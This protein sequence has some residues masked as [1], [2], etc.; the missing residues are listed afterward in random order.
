VLLRLCFTT[1]G[2]FFTLV[3]AVGIAIAQSSNAAVSK[4]EPD[5][6]AH[7][8]QPFRDPRGLYSLSMPPGWDLTL[9]GE[10]P[11]FHNG[12]S[13]IQVRLLNAPSPAAAVD[14]AAAEFRGHFTTFNT[15]NR[16]ETI[17]AGRQSHGQNI[18]AVTP[19]GERVSVLVTAQPTPTARQF[20][21]LISST[22][23][24]QAPQLNTAVM[25]FATSVRFH[26]Q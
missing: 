3:L 23:V 1:I 20:L 4:H 25:A 13:W 8:G 24:T 10:D 16:G 17:I 11:T 15:I 7:P 5:A 19:T 12:S 2:V 9:S 18:D 14:I 21:V 26:A 6:N 22:P